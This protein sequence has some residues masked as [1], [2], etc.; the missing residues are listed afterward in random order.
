M[1][2]SDSCQGH[3]SNAGL[4]SV[5]PKVHRGGTRL[6]CQYITPPPSLRANSHTMEALLKSGNDDSFLQGAAGL[7]HSVGRER[8]QPPAGREL[9]REMPTFRT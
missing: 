9:W 5:P 4:Q 6:Q 2:S 1:S 3:R 7:P 8:I